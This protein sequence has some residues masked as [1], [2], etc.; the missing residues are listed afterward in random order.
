MKYLFIDIRK[1]DE[2]YRKHFLPSEQYKFYNIPM[3]MIRF[4][5]ET[6]IEHLEYVDEIYIV[7]Q[8]ANRSQF[9]KDKYFANIEKIK[10]NPDLQFGNLK[11]GINN[12]VLKDKPINVNVGGK[13]EFNLYNVMR[14]L[15]LV[16]GTVILAAGGYTYLQLK[17]KKIKIN[18]IPLI[19][20]L[21]MGV[22]AIYNGLTSTC[23]L[24]TALMDKLN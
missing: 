15:Q 16:M 3:N 5:K 19:I 17:N 20:L 18:K 2:A 14:I 6:I 9:V 8:G 11:P 10:V 1:S 21:I 12:I 7:C 13:D 22:N 23:S 4:N 24:S